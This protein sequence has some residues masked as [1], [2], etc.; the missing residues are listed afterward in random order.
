MFSF[1][2]AIVIAKTIERYGLLFKQTNSK[3]R[4]YVSKYLFNCY[5]IFEL[6]SIIENNGI[7]NFINIETVK[8]TISVQIV[9]I[10]I[11]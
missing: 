10:Y 2:I 7:P 9:Y 4:E 8:L 5:I 11:L 1:N 6:Y 3:E